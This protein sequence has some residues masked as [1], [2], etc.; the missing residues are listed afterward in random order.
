[1]PPGNEPWRIIPGGGE[2]YQ[3]RPGKRG[4]VGEGRREAVDALRD[5]TKARGARR[6]QGR[7]ELTHE[8]S[9]RR[10]RSTAFL[11]RFWR[12]PDETGSAG[13]ETVRGF[14][15][16]LRNGEEAF[17]ADPDELPGVLRAALGELRPRRAGLPDAVAGE[18][19][20]E[21]PTSPTETHTKRHS[22][23]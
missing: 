16:N 11:V 6:A 22:R 20:P 13:A 7:A 23:R 1:M 9:P 4:A 19:P 15:R 3:A 8:E 14:V 21:G 10:P 18:E 12:E 5:E 17:V 2:G